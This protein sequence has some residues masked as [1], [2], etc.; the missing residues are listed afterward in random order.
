MKNDTLEFLRKNTV[1]WSRMGFAYDPPIYDENGE[2]MLISTETDKYSRYHDQFADIG[3]DV[4]SHILHSGWMGVDKYDYSLCDSTLEKIFA[5]GKVK[6]LIPRVKL[7]VPPEWCKE[8]PEDTFVYFEGP[9]SAEEISALAM[10]PKQDYLGYEA[11]GGYYNAGA[12]KDT[13]PNVGGLISLQS[14]SSDKWIH[15]ASVA[16][17]NLIEHIENGKYGKKILAYHICYGACG[18]SMLWGRNSGRYG[19]YGIANQKKFLQWATEKYGSKQMAYSAW[20]ISEEDEVV[21]P[22]HKREN[23]SPKNAGE[24]F[25]SDSSDLWS[26]DYDRFM[27]D[28][29]VG[30]LAAF[31]KVAKTASGGKPVGAFYGY[32]LHMERCA[33]TGHLAWEKLL[34]VPDIDFFAAPKSYFRCGP[35]EPGG[36]MAPVVTINSKKLWMDECDIRTYLAGADAL[37]KRIGIADNAQETKT[38]MLREMCKNISHNSTMWYMDLGGG[39]Y[40]EPELLEYMGKL[41]KAKN[42]IDLKEYKS[43]AQIA[44]IIDEDAVIYN[45][46]PEFNKV[47]EKALR[48][49]QLCGAPID[50]LL[51]SC[52]DSYSFENT[53]L[54]FVLNGYTM[55]KEYLDALRKRLPDRCRIMW[56]NVAGITG[57]ELSFENVRNLSGFDIRLSDEKDE[58]GNFPMFEITDGVKLSFGEDKNGRCVIGANSNG[59][60]LSV[61]YDDCAEMY[62]RVVE[63]CGVDTVSPVYSTV[64]ADSRIISVFAQ[65]D[66]SFKICPAE[67]EMLKDIITGDIIKGTQKIDLSAK[68]GIAFEIIK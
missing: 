6:Y 44:A 25:K 51:S 30:A 26:L 54:V 46:C 53:K 57:K 55:T 1:F 66:I 28:V 62:R 61:V 47:T 37:A 31:S 67:N 59:D 8:N 63:Y 12:W 43:T 3:V 22:P 27:N 10:T 65:R 18:E 52:T 68:Q 32:V 50:T 35:G 13:R 16:L 2:I 23:L 5:S 11:P 21:P 38:V 49:L 48:N 60:I 45:T 4:H 58:N 29:N 17:E 64:Y 14:F 36:E 34:S 39:W 56:I 42:N 9:R 41:I 40:D 24:L 33:Y 19:D 15:D 7:N 20:G